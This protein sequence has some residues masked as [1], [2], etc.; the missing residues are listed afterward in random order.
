MAALFVPNARMAHL[1]IKKLQQHACYATGGVFKMFPDRVFACYVSIIVQQQQEEWCIKQNA[2]AMLAMCLRSNV[3][4]A[5]CVPHYTRHK[6]FCV[7]DMEHAQSYNQHSWPS[8]CNPLVFI[9]ARAHVLAK[10]EC[11]SMNRPA[12]ATL[13][14]L[15]VGGA[16]IPRKR[17]LFAMR[18]VRARNVMRMLTCCSR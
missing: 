7:R 2:H 6:V 13:W 15:H 5:N 17:N 8:Q 18:R 12:L 9:C 3:T 14:G 10:G 1:R 16:K 4:A 11:H